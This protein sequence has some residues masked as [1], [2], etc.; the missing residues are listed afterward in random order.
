MMEVLFTVIVFA[1]CGYACWKGGRDGRLVSALL[2]LAGIMTVVVKAL[3]DHTWAQTNIP[4]LV[5]DLSLLLALA[6]VAKSTRYYWPVWI[7]GLHLA[8]I[9]TH[10][11]AGLLDGGIKPV[12]YYNMQSF[13]SI[14]ELVIMVLG[15][16]TDRRYGLLK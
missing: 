3:F 16:A 10:F 15:I 7:C 12:V 8:S 1:C 9:A 4:V 5:V 13:W 2:I 14:P 6:W 11:G